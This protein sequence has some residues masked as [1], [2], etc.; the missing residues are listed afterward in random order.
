[1]KR[2]AYVVA[3]IGGLLVIGLIAHTGYR[4]VLNALAIGGWNL[5]WLLP[6]HL[7]PIALDA[8]GWRLLIVRP[9]PYRRARWGVL[10]WIALVRE[11]VGRLLPVASVGG[12]IAGIRLL[13]LRGVDGATATASVVVEVLISLLSQYLFTAIGVALLI[14]LTQSNE[15]TTQVLI[16]IALTCPAPI[17]V[18]LL[19]DNAGIFQRLERFAERTL[20][21]RSRLTQLLSGGATLDQEIEN[22]IAHRWRL[23][24]ATVWQ[25]LGMVSGSFEVWLALHLLGHPVGVETAV[26][27]ESVTLTI[28][29]LAFLVPGGLGVQEA[30]LMVFGQMLGLSNETALALSLIKRGRE[31]VIGIPILLSWQIY[32]ARQLRSG[33]NG[34]RADS[35]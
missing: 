6:Y 26:I 12:E 11:G 3:L 16:G 4:A 18:L 35:G 5:L 20:G 19:L 7:C 29:H 21:G 33:H 30:G 8:W 10:T 2:L 31:L 15:T 34:K 28:R 22:V 9:D 27:L 17:I 14:I 23:A 13:I 32:E 1:M 25:L 24:K